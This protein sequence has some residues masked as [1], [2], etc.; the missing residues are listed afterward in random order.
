MN[1]AVIIVTLQISLQLNKLNYSPAY[2][3]GGII[4]KRSLLFVRSLLLITHGRG[5]RQVQCQ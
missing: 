5:S 2:L 4:I 1:V 3:N